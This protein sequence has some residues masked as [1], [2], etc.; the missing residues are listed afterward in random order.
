MTP[1]SYQIDVYTIFV[2]VS[3]SLSCEVWLHCSPK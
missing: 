1:L 3:Y 2:I